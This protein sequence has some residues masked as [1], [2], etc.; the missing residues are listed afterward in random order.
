M[1][2]VRCPRLVRATRPLTPADTSRPILVRTPRAPSA[3]GVPATLQ[4]FITYAGCRQQRYRTHMTHVRHSNPPGSRFTTCNGRGYFS[5]PHHRDRG[6]FRTKSIWAI[7]DES[8]CHVFC[9]TERREPTKVAAP[10]QVWA[11]ASDL[12]QPFGTRGEVLARFLPPQSGSTDWHGHPVGR[13]SP[14][15]TKTAPAAV[16]ASWEASG[17]VSH[18]LAKKL[19][20]QVL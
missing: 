8:E 1:R 20:K 6:M 19:R 13:G 2:S 7:S 14:G 17:L 12:T 9:D 18:A 5:H 3:S 16:I 11:V 15:S 4:S 10:S